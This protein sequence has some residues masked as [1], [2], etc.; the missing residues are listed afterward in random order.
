MKDK[1]LQSEWFGLRR[2]FDNLLEVILKNIRRDF[3]FE[4]GEDLCGE[5]KLNEEFDIQI[6]NVIGFK[7]AIPNGAKYF[8]QELG[9]DWGRGRGSG[10][11]RQS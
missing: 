10:E 5:T 6:R 8:F 1:E 2:I 7:A 4:K 11:R 9:R 3:F